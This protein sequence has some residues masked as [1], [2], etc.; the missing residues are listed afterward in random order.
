MYATLVLLTR[1]VAMSKIQLNQANSLPF[2]FLFMA[3][4][5]FVPTFESP[6]LLSIFGISSIVRAVTSV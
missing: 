5:L 1:E 4:G 3:N 6:S 2:D